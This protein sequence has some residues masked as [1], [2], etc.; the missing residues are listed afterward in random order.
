VVPLRQAFART[1]VLARVQLSL[2]SYL[3]SYLTGD[4]HWALL[5]AGA[6]L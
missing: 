3:V 5:A 4:L 1:R 2:T 6:A